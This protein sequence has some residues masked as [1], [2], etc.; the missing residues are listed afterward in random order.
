MTAQGAASSSQPSG[1]EPRRSLPD[2]SH[3]IGIGRASSLKAPAASAPAA[4]SSQRLEAAGAPPVAPP[5]SSGG[6]RHPLARTL[7]PPRSQHLPKCQTSGP[8]TLHVTGEK[9]RHRDSEQRPQPRA[10]SEQPA[11]TR[12]PPL[13]R[14]GR[15]LPGLLPACPPPPRAGSRLLSPVWPQACAL[16]RVAAGSRGPA[17]SLLRMRA[18]GAEGGPRGSPRLLTALPSYVQ[19]QPLLPGGQGR[20]PPLALT[21]GW[22]W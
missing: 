3:G 17:P 18:G 12:P 10:A 6:V 15:A 20:S 11:E 8:Q 19:A 22:P 9:L 2:R 7:R 21:K 1:Q 5:P 13:T 4:P 14:P 16:R